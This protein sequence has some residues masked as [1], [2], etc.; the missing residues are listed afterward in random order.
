[1]I[2]IGS[3]DRSSSLLRIELKKK[4]KDLKSFQF[5]E[6]FNSVGAGTSVLCILQTLLIHPKESKYYSCCTDD[7]TEPQRFHL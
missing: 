5:R 3:S 7:V 4:K 6:C 1:M 2:R